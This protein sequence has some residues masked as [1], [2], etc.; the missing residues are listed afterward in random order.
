[1]ST[2]KFWTQLGAAAA[3]TAG[4]ISASAHVQK[5][6]AVTASN[7]LMQLADTAGEGEGEEVASTDDASY[8]AQLGYVLGHMRVGTALYGK[9]E[10]DMAKTHMKHPR[11]EI[12]AELEPVLKE[13]KV[14]GFAVE[15]DALSTA[16]AAGA[17]AVDAEAKFKALE[18]AVISNMPKM[19][20][21]LT[22]K[23]VQQMVRT[24]GE[25][26][27]I[28]IKNGKID[29]LHEYQDAWGFVET[30]KSLMVS[31]SAEERTEHKAEVEAIDA[32]LAGLS[33]LWPDITGKA[34][35][36]GETK[37]LFAAAAKIELQALAME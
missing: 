2:I 35:V 34:E 13:R 14:P 20:A 10:A 26:Y 11:D 16:V 27:A 29:N 8:V 36:K 30:A 32:E 7:P 37:Q 23:A 25:E 24:A 4:S 33:S 19:S 9:G 15:L 12:Y 28:G 31:L 17:P 5:L 18:A 21:S 22:A 6:N 1:M 3:L